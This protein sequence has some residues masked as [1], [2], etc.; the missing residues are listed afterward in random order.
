[1]KRMAWI[2]IVTALL[3][4][5]LA[6]A[7]SVADIA[8][9]NRKAKAQQTTNKV[10][11]NDNIPR[12]QGLSVVGPQPS[13][14]ATSDSGTQAKAAPAQSK[15]SAV[16]QSD[17]TKKRVDAQKEKVDTLSKDLDLTQREYRLRAVAM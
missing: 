7:Q 14:N 15:P 11:D 8:R 4:S 3:L 16:D 6:S 13:S 5:G 9:A 12:E 2:F 1:M 10:Y 17:A